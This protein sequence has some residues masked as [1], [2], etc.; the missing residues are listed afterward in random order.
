MTVVHKGGW[1]RA[2]TSYWVVP[3]VLGVGLALAFSDGETGYLAWSEI[4]GNLAESQTRIEL[5]MR[6]VDVLQTEIQSL[7]ED[8]F[9]LE[10][11]I[12]EELKLARPGE[13]VVRFTQESGLQ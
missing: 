2:L 4:R 7:E 10:R 5:L 3:A 11:A 13:I 1:V 6:R 12:R 8:P 9:A